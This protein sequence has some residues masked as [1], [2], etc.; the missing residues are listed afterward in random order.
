MA[1]KKVCVSRYTKS[2]PKSKRGRFAKK[3]AAKTRRQCFKR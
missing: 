1:K 3:G 2:A